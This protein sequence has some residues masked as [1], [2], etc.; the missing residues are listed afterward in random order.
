M[1]DTAAR[2]AIGLALLAAVTLGLLVAAKREWI[3]STIQEIW[4]S[5][6]VKEVVHDVVDMVEPL[7]MGPALELVSEW[8]SEA[9]SLDGVLSEGEWDGAALTHFDGTDRLRPGV[10]SSRKDSVR[11]RETSGVVPYSSN[12]AT[13]YVMND[14]STVFAAIDVADDVLDFR[15][16]DIAKRDSIEIHLCDG[17]QQ[18]TRIR[19][20]TQHFLLVRGD[21][22]AAVG[23]LPEGA[24]VASVKPD[25]SGYTVEFVWS[26]NADES[27]IGFDIGVND[28]DSP[29]RE[30]L[31]RQYYLNGTDDNLVSEDREFGALQLSEKK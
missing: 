17:A 2:N 27:P 28:N 7:Q 21:G 15:D 14:E 6:D 13:F 24:Y 1:K 20:K 22:E 9:P 10:A 4:S 25:R 30:G 8:T 12:H 31:H 16:G 26:W 5:P 23:G 18:K 29:S 11:N 19:G 3:Q